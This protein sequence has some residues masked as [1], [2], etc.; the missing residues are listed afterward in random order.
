MDDEDNDEEEPK[1]I[2]SNPFASMSRGTGQEYVIVDP[3][4]ASVD[5]HDNILE[6][7]QCLNKST[8]KKLRKSQWHIGDIMPSQVL[9]NSYRHSVDP[10][11]VKSREQTLSSETEEDDLERK[12]EEYF[13]ENTPFPNNAPPHEDDIRIVVEGVSVDTYDA[14]DD[15]RTTLQEKRVV[16]CRLIRD[17][18]G[19]KC[20]EFI[21]WGDSGCKERRPSKR[22]ELRT[23]L[24]IPAGV[25][26][27]AVST[28]GDKV[29]AVL[30]GDPYNLHVDPD[31]TVYQF[32]LSP[33]I[34]DGHQYY[35]PPEF[36][37][38]AENEV[39]AIQ[40]TARDH[41]LVGTDVSTIELWDCSDRSAP[42][43]I[44]ILRPPNAN[45]F[46][47]SMDDTGYMNGIT[48]FLPPGHGKLQNFFF[49]TQDNGTKGV[50]TMWQTQYQNRNRV[51]EE[52]DF[53]MM[54]RVKYE[55]YINFASNGHSL[56]VLAHDKFGS[57]YLD[58]YHLPGSRYV[59]NEF[60]DVSLPKGVEFDATSIYNRD[61]SDFYTLSDSG[62]SRHLKFANRINIRHRVDVE[63]G[64]T[65]DFTMD[66]NDR[67]LVIEAHDGI[68]DSNGESKSEGPGLIVI[69]L[70]E[71]I[72]TAR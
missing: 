66:M 16:L 47:N 23:I 8:Q 50:I 25:Y 44:K 54:V 31:K 22:F 61:T 4:L 51:L 21:V 52:A 46:V 11:I 28:N 49:S 38:S 33:N 12:W 37:F 63:N 40:P 48:S 27:D 58:V 53:R 32:S 41:V 55:G 70:D 30:D 20:T 72:W 19:R 64:Y 35:I 24:R 18:D 62:A 67:F 65:D 3:D 56:M 10:D 36:Y 60:D 2:M 42:N 14:M 26:D 29:Y 39:T 9:L 45:A 69:D 71:N 34:Q 6:R 59:L 15:D 7:V 5:V 17:Q 13:G 68:V 57:L 43:R 1:D